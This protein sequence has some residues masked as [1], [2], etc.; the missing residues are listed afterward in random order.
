MSAQPSLL[1][2]TEK[3]DFYAHKVSYLHIH[4]VRDMY[5]GYIVLTVVQGMIASAHA[6]Q[7]KLESE[8]LLEK[9]FRE[10][11]V[12]IRSTYA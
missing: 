5:G 2:M 7:I 9:A 4:S 1:T 10:N 3:G 11:K 8:R 12:N 6:V